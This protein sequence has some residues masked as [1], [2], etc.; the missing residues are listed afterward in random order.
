M[1][2]DDED[3]K[4]LEE[5]EL[6]EKQVDEEKEEEEEKEGDEEEKQEDKTNESEIRRKKI[7]RAFNCIWYRLFY[8]DSDKSLRCRYVTPPLHTHI[9]TYIHK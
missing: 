3:V 7:L 1:E 8:E 2:M 6:E 9:H 5:K 4:E